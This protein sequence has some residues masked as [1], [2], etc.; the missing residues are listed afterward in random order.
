MYPKRSTL[1]NINCA[2][3]NKPFRVVPSRLK[4]KGTRFCSRFC[5]DQGRKET[6]KERFWR[7]VTISPACWEWNGTKYK[8]GYGKTWTSGKN[9]KTLSAHRVSWELHNG[10]IPQG[11]DVLHSCDNPPCVKPDHLFLGNDQDNADDKVRKGRQAKGK[12]VLGKRCRHD[13]NS[14]P[15][16]VPFSSSAVQAVPVSGET[17]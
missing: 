16:S 3:C 17:S 8:Q 7:H 11:I 4:R 15:N 5:C 1:P 10:P 6:L 2:H 14:T 9:P 12:S 13:V